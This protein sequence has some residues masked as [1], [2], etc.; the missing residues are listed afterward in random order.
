MK[1]GITISLDHILVGVVKQIADRDNRSVSN[2]VET[3][4]EQ[5]VRR[6]QSV[7]PDTDVIPS[8]VES[9]GC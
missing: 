5:M 1:I 3:E 7:I 2:L 9:H 4:L 8:P 6:R